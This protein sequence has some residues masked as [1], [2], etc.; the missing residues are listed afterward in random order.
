LTDWFFFC[1]KT[2]DRTETANQLVIPRPLTGAAAIVVVVVVV[3]TRVGHIEMSV[4]TRRLILILSDCPIDVVS[5][6]VAGG[7]AHPS[8][9]GKVVVVVEAVPGYG[10]LPNFISGLEGRRGSRGRQVEQDFVVQLKSAENGNDISLK[11]ISLTDI[12]LTDISLT[13]ILFKDVSIRGYFNK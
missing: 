11:D 2:E 13:D 1:N 9:V 7:H 8:S 5:D 6:S 12:S 10:G 3:G 4:P